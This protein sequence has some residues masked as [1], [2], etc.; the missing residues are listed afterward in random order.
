M[1]KLK[2]FAVMVTVLFLFGMGIS[3]AKA[4]KKFQKTWRLSFNSMIFQGNWV[5]NIVEKWAK[6]IEEATDGG[7]KMK[8]YWPG[9]LP[10]KGHQSLPA[11]KDR[12]VDGAECNA[13]YYGNTHPLVNTTYMFFQFRTQEEFMRSIKQVIAKSYKP[14]F[15]KYNAVVLISTVSGG[16]ENFFSKKSIT[17]L[18]D[19]KGMK[20]RAYSKSLADMIKS[21]GGSPITIPITELYMALQRGAV[22]TDF[23]SFN[24]ANDVKFWEVM[25]Y[26]TEVGYTQGGY[27]TVCVNK[28]AWNEVPEKY[29]KVIRKISNRY[30]DLIYE[31]AVKNEGALRENFKK[32]GGKILQLEPGEREKMEESVLLLW[33]AYAEKAGD[34]GVGMLGDLEKLFNR[35]I[36]KRIGN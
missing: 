5:G 29:Q 23:T 3:D 21:L 18:S 34:G 22:Q 19:L 8:F 9:A 36:L 16:N 12:L 10:Y 2:I 26:A 4:P 1:R 13:T 14:I 11:V 20:I 27:N 15:D 31:A 30:S 6:E 35:P 24:T 32:H 17:K 7:L 33:K 25:K 28:D